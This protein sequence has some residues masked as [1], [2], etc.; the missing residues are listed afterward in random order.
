MS[1]SIIPPSSSGIWGAPGGCL[2]WVLMNAMYPETEETQ[3]SKEGTASHEIGS[4]LIESAAT[5]K[6]LT[7]KDFDGR[8]ATNGV[9]F[10]EEMY[11]GAR[12]Y[13]DEA[14]GLMQ[15]Y[16]VFAGM[17]LGI[18]KK[19]KAP[20]IHDLSEG[21]PDFYLYAK[22]AQNL[23]ILD[24]KYGHRP[25]PTFENWQLIN[26]LSG[27][28]EELEIDGF[29]EQKLTVHFRIVQPRA[30]QPGG[31]VQ[32]WDVLASDLRGHVNTLAKNAGLSLQDGAPCTSGSHCRDCHARPHCKA[33][34][35]GGWQL[36]EAA[37]LPTPQEL[38]PEALGVQLGII[39][40]AH[41]QLGYLKIGLEE[42]GLH[43]AKG[44]AN[45]AGFR[46]EP[47]YGRE[48]WTKSTAEV[49]AL[50]EMLEIDLRK[51]EAPVTPKQ[52]ISRGVDP[53][54]ITAY[55]ETPRTGLKL[56]QDKDNKAARVFGGNL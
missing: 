51:P 12:L 17:N 31:P 20:R 9:L 4:E 42:R 45:V 29:E 13:A 30:Y 40:R 52:A 47:T 48:K 23:Y 36:Y 54:V 38:S 44:G 55:S 26:Y 8:A 15:K 34:N 11:E 50:G 16:A 25:V 24:Y 41:E 1:H 18:E 43:L 35:L 56:V 19:V 2:G 49:V 6:F 21:T 27:I 37:T 53:A 3:E 32:K 39:T 28:L 46:A 22:E 7:W 33:A 5:A 10:T 14:I